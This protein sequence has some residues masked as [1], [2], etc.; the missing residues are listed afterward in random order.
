M[1]RAEELDSGAKNT[2]IQKPTIT[3]FSPHP[4]YYLLPPFSL[5]LLLIVVTQIRGHIAGSSPP[6][7]L[8]FV[9]CII[10][11]EKISALS[12]LVGL[13]RTAVLTHARHSATVV[14]PFIFA[15]KLKIS[16]RRDS[17]SRTNTIISAGSDRGLPREHRGDRLTVGHR[18]PGTCI[19]YVPGIRVPVLGLSE[20]NE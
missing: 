2:N 13:R 18:K 6:S 7:P 14:D 8:R 9:P 10:Y 1:S 11:R 5:S 15:N 17:N 20:N 4:I 3:F 19:M 12:S 16:S